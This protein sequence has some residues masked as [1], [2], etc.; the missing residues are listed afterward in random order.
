MK[1][2]GCSKCEHEEVGTKGGGEKGHNQFLTCMSDSLVY[3]VL[4]F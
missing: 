3:N 1:G 4:D 2:R